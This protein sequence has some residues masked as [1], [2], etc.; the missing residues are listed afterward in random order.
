M[1]RLIL[2][3]SHAII[4]RAYYALPPLSSPSG[5]PTNAVYGFTTI[6]MRMLKELKPDYIAACFDMATPTFRH[7]V[8]ERYKAQRP[9]VPHD[10]SSQFSLVK[11]VLKAFDI[12]ILE[13]EGY[14]AD[15]IIG[16]LA[17]KFRDERDVEI[18]VVTGDLDTLQ[19][20]RPRLKVYSMKKGISEIM[21]YDE[22]A[23]EERYGL[24]PS[25][26]IDF[27]GLKGDPSDNIPGVRGIGEKT[28]AEL[29]ASF[30]SLE[31]VYKALRSG[32]KKVSKNIAEKLFA[33]EED[34]KFSKELARIIVD[35]P[36]RVGL[37]DLR[38]KE[39]KDFSK[40]KDVFS[41]LGFSSL[42]KRLDDKIK[43]V[44]CHAAA[45]LDG[46][47]VARLQIKTIK[48][49][50]GFEEF[51]RKA[52]DGDHGIILYE[53]RLYSVLSQVLGDC[54]IAAAPPAIAASLVFEW[55]SDILY[56]KDVKAFWQHPPRPLFVYDGK[57]IIR[58][59]RNFGIEV[60]PI[61]FDLM[62][63][64]YLGGIFG[65]DFSY[66][67]LVTQELGHTIS[68][69]PR[70]ELGRFFEVA[71]ALEGKL[72]VG[73]VR[74]VFEKI[75]LPLVRVLA[76]ME[77]RGIK[78]DVDVLKKL[79]GEIDKRLV[80]L[81][82]EIYQLSGGPF[83]INSSQQLA[84]V[85]FEKL[86]LT[87]RGLRKTAKAGR[88]STGAAELDKLKGAHP[89]IKK[90]LEYRE[91]TK[92]KT[93]Y[94]DALPPLV[95][96]ET[97]R[98]HTTFNQIGTVTGRLSSSDP[99]LQ[100]IPIMSELGREI[101]KAF[102]AEKGFMLVSFDYSQIELR[103][104]AHLANDE[105]MLDA[106]Q[107]GLD[108]HKMTAAEIFN[109]PL[110]G[111]T[112]EQRRAAKTLNFGILYGMGP[113]ALAES[114]GMSKDEAKKFIDE[115]FLDF[116]GIK[117]YIENT[118]KFAAKNGYVETLFGRRRYIPEVH[119]PNWQ[120]KREAER[121]AVNMPIQGTAT[122]DIIKLAM[123]KVDEWIR[124]EKLENDIRMLLQVH[125]ELLFEV[126]EGLSQTWFRHKETRF[127]GDFIEKIQRI[128]KIMENVVELKVPLAVDVKI[129]KN[130]GEQKAL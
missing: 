48:N 21:I 12:P 72:T 14:E 87:S 127:G 125:D 34:A 81:T 78:V 65:R 130:W 57:S 43:P 70:E 79:S 91:L 31:G 120:L 44:G 104:A 53:K 49:L 8:Y 29:I 36:I 128:K 22:K 10:L 26:L 103:V 20:V 76:D 97:E 117:R 121:M 28:A 30:G 112:Q 106:F 13:K 17:E 24:K 46:F 64:A 3:D 16:T 80:K 107:R 23:V 95:N 126:R 1:K 118:L 60:G 4:H 68:Q 99:N 5:E 96:P 11:E 50:S 63:A 113:Q 116:S 124:K 58:F 54:G 42:L 59:L 35:I 18:V 6:L 37:E 39:P 75:E 86:K 71:R 100:N 98:L 82:E 38:W 101:R 73:R 108:I 94:V 85:L 114:T 111:V 93:T 52:K 56:K 41:R 47:T 110:R 19:L 51:R 15:D 69:A 92:L 55:S 74:D 45:L 9:E 89:I 40:I 122:G 2:I 109:I 62:L 61:K 90:I 102:V 129:G 88:V 7:I 67:A 83:N 123:I 33:G 27:K 25:Q 66:P 84:A 115:Y 119:S 105:K 77:D 32:N